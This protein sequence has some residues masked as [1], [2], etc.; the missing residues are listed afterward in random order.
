M[1]GIIFFLLQAPYLQLQTDLFS[2]SLHVGSDH[3]VGTESPTGETYFLI[4]SYYFSFYAWIGTSLWEERNGNVQ[5]INRCSVYA[6]L[7][8]I[9]NPEH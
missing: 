2:H 9:H 1:D 4:F 6:P 7:G 3:R 5:K 8:L